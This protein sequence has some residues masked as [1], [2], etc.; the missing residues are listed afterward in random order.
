VLDIGMMYAAYGLAQ[1]GFTAPAASSRATTCPLTAWHKVWQDYLDGVRPIHGFEPGKENRAHVGE[2][3]KG[4]GI[5]AR[6]PLGKVGEEFLGWMPISGHPGTMVWNK[7]NPLLRATYEAAITGKDS[8]GR[9]IYNPHPQTIAEQ[10]ERARTAVLHIAKSLG[11]ADFLE[12]G[13]DLATGQA[14]GDK[15]VAAARTLGPITGLGSIS[16][17]NPGGP[18]IGVERAQIEHDR[19]YQTQAKQE[20]RRLY[21]LGEEEKARDA[22]AKGY[23]ED[24]R[25]AASAWRSIVNPNKAQVRLNR[26]FQRTA[27]D[28]A[29]ARA[30]TVTGR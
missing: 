11:P 15:E 28:E 16:Q 22:L 19:Y 27:S 7:L 8:L 3:T 30:A 24:A 26:Q 14:H 18:E 10:L 21:S 6:A 29:R 12:Q 25:G 13:Y 1:S 4:R 9:D 23:G 17:G 20:A 5:Y 2:D